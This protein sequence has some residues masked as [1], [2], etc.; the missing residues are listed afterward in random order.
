MLTSLTDNA[1]RDRSTT[2]HLRL[3]GFCTCYLPTERTTRQ[4]K[5]QGVSY[6]V[7]AL[8]LACSHIYSDWR[9][10]ILAGLVASV[11]ETLR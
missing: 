6:V 4:V 9:Q 11:A 2:I 8:W 7:A 1:Q 5:P 3:V 10:R